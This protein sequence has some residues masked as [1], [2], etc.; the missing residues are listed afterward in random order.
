[1]MNGL[2]AAIPA[3]AKKYAWNIKYGLLG[4]PH[5]NAPN[6]IIRYLSTQLPVTASLLDL[7]CGRGSL[8]R[9]LRDKGWI[10]S[11]CGVDISQLAID[12]A[13]K[14]IDQRSSW[15]VSDFESFHSQL[16]W[17]IIAM[18]ESVYYVRLV[19]L[20]VFLSCMMQ[21]LNPDGF[22]VFRL[23]DLEKH[24]AYAEVVMDLYPHAEKVD[25][26]LFC[27]SDSKNRSRRLTQ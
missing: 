24:R 20:P 10:G 16:R 17:D 5:F 22:F 15:V 6:D 14:I 27:I 12:D 18:V 25:Q 3:T 1:M 7:G 19:Q 11:Y 21:T 8:L 2:R 4:Y 26:N 9:A 13:R 23:H